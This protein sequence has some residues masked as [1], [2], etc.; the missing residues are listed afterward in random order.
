[1]LASRDVAGTVI[2]AARDAGSE[3]V[4]IG[5]VTRNDWRDRWRPTVVDRIIDGLPDADIHVIARIAK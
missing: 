2:Q 3:H 1:V 5:E 4:V